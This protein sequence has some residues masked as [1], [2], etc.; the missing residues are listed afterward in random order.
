MTADELKHYVV[1]QNNALYWKNPTSNRVKV[2][3]K[4]GS[5]Q[6]NGY[7]GTTIN[8]QFWYIHQLVY[9][10][11]NP[12]GYSNNFVIDHIDNNRTNN[13]IKNLRLVSV[14]E[15]NFNMSNTKGYIKHKDKYVA[16][17]T[18]NKQVYQI[19]TFATPEEATKAYNTVKPVLHVFAAS[20]PTP[21][22]I[23]AKIKEIRPN[24]RLCNTSGYEGVHKRPNGTWQARVTVNGKRKSLGHFTTPEKAYSAIKEYHK[25]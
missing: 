2:G 23:R 13:S 21:E 14:Q 7:L 5:K 12:E 6:P 8:K 18:L 1:Y 9:L 11:H 15:N 3:D 4:V 19:G 20:F 10:Y 25:K 24:K 22:E 17:I 16:K